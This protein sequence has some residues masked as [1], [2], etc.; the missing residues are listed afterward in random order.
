MVYVELHADPP[1]LEQHMEVSRSVRTER[2]FDVVAK[3]D[4]VRGHVRKKLPFALEGQIDSFV[5][6]EKKRFISDLG[7]KCYL[8]ITELDKNTSDQQVAYQ[9]FQLRDVFKGH[10]GLL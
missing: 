2:F 4:I 8:K 5:G 7:V 6:L 1:P 3:G 10:A 9:D